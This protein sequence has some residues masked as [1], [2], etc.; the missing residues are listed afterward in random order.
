[1]PTLVFLHVNQGHVGVEEILRNGSWQPVLVEMAKQKTTKIIIILILNLC[2]TYEYPQ[3]LRYEKLIQSGSAS[4]GNGKR[5]AEM[6]I[7]Q[8]QPI[9]L[10]QPADAGWYLSRQVIRVQSSDEESQERG[11]LGNPKSS[12]RSVDN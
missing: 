9:D 1:M 6:I 8:I 4:W 11:R 12:R 5:P 3:V 2:V 10:W 7:S